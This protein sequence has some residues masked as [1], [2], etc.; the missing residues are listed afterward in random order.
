MKNTFALMLSLVCS[1]SFV[2]AQAPAPAQES[3]PARPAAQ[4]PAAPAAQQPAS[5]TSKVTYFGAEAR[6]M[7]IRGAR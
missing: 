7:L 3:A 4:Q 5:A 2:A 6:T 1:I